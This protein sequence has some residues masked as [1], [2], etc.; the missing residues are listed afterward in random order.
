MSTKEAKLTHVFAWG[1]EAWMTQR[2][3]KYSVSG[4][5]DGREFDIVTDMPQEAEKAFAHAARSAWLR[6]KFRRLRG[7]PAR[8]SSPVN[9]L[10]TYHE[11]SLRMIFVAVVTALWS[12]VFR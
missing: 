10:D 1:Y 5:I 7:L 4:Y 9:S 12:R 11:V 8:E 3:G 2:S 6:R